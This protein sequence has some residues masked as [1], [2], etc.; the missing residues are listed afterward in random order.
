MEKAVNKMKSEEIYLHVFIVESSSSS[1][2]LA[3]RYEG[4]VLHKFLIWRRIRS[5]HYFAIDKDSF[6]RAIIGLIDDAIGE[7]FKV[8]GLSILNNKPIPAILPII[9]IS[10]YGNEKGIF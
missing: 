10:A 5:S 3:K 9:H 8:A 6:N 4:E 2:F 1:D 7:G